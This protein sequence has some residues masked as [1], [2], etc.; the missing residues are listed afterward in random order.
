MKQD[1]KNKIK[2][3]S[4]MILWGRDDEAE[5]FVMENPYLK[6]FLDRYDIRQKRK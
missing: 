6:E 1:L 5:A 2:E 4:E 3:Y